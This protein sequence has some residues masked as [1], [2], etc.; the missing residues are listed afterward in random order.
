MRPSPHI[1]PVYS[2]D[3]KSPPTSFASLSDFLLSHT[4]PHS[5]H[6]S[7]SNSRN[8]NQ[9]CK[10]K[11][12]VRIHFYSSNST[13]WRRILKIN[14][15]MKHHQSSLPSPVPCPLL[16]F[17]HAA[18]HIHLHLIRNIKPL[19]K[20]IYTLVPP[21]HTPRH[22]QAHK[23][24]WAGL[25]EKQTKKLI[26]LCKTQNEY[27]EYQEKLM[28]EAT[29]FILSQQRP[30]TKVE[31]LSM[32]GQTLDTLPEHR[33]FSS[34]TTDDFEKLRAGGE[35]GDIFINENTIANEMRGFKISDD[36]WSGLQATRQVMSR[37]K[38]TGV[39]HVIGHF[40]ILATLIARQ[41]FKEERLIVHP[42]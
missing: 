26:K 13:R 1:P 25:D 7:W 4:P 8:Q 16:T 22:F 38:E 18:I 15:L 12:F 40:L 27:V 21:D 10:I 19:L 24:P 34:L 35:R 29:A 11:S 3:S 31:L 20:R 2:T 5:A 42:E 37:V 39:R 33:T 6:P 41:M 17:P 14:N 32:M 36:F 30:A 9:Q 23:S 28:T